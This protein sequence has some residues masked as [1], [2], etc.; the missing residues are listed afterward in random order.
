MVC[1]INSRR[2]STYLSTHGYQFVCQLTA[3]NSSV[4]SPAISLSVNSQLSTRLRFIH[5]CQLG[6]QLIC[7]LTAINSSEIRTHL[8]AG[9]ARSTHS[10]YQLIC[11]AINSSVSS[12]LSTH[13]YQLV[14]Q[15]TAINSSVNSSAISLSGK[16]RVPRKSR[17]R[18][19]M[20]PLLLNHNIFY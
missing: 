1:K 18:F 9:S 4:N 17:W 12:Q 15:L 7:Q 6:Y 19:E 2:L 20:L 11:M 16:Q 8:S 13:G 5:M 10:D 14:C 3:L